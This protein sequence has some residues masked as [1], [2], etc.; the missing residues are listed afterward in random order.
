MQHLARTVTR[1]LSTYVD[2][3]FRGDNHDVELRKVNSRWQVRARGEGTVTFRDTL[4]V[5]R[6]ELRKSLARLEAEGTAESIKPAAHAHFR[7]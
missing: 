2:S 5:F 3:S 1:L 7:A 6:R 4:A